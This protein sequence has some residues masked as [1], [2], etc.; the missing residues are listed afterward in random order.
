MASILCRNGSEHKHHSVY[1]SKVCWGIVSR[2]TPPPPV[3]RTLSDDMA[4]DPQVDYLVDLGE[5][6]YYAKSLTKAQA[7]QRI[8]DIKSGKVKPVLAPDEPHKVDS[9][10]TTK[11]DLILGLL[12]MIPKGYYAV[13]ADETSPIIF[14]R[15]ARPKNKRY[16][17]PDVKFQTQHGPRFED[18]WALWPSG[19]VSIFKTGIE[20][21][22]LLLIADYQGAMHRYAERIGNCMRCNTELTD[23]RS[24]HYGVGPDCEE[25]GMYWVIDQ[26]DEECGGPWE[27]LPIERWRNQ[28]D[29]TRH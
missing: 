22:I 3:S 10:K 1:E 2:P 26:V 5:S 29:A 27:S 4:T 28:T 20:D 7:S 9:P 16:T 12:D 15:C 21:S 19:E 25:M 18:A 11:T 14:M 6:R 17:Q 24:R 8:K 23:P 13:Q